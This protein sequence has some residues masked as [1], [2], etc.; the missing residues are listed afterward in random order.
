MSGIS[1]SASRDAKR[2]VSLLLFNDKGITYLDESTFGT[3]M[4]ENPLNEVITHISCSDCKNVW[5]KKP[6]FKS[7]VNGLFCTN[8]RKLVDP[9]NFAGC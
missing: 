8:G 1:K 4:T 3:F 2:P 9:R 6:E 7:H 5:L